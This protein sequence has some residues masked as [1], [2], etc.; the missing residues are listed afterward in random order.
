MRD[1]GTCRF[2]A[3]SRFSHAEEVVKVARKA[4]EIEVAAFKGGGAPA[5][6]STL[7]KPKP[8]KGRAREKY[9]LCRS[10]A[11]TKKCKFETSV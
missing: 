8:G 9:A 1:N 7:K 11:E 5:E 4:A 2:G 6:S 10:F 3:N